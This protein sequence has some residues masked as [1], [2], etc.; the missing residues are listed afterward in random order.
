MRFAF[1]ICLLNSRPGVKCCHRRVWL[2]AFLWLAFVS[3]LPALENEMVCRESQTFLAPGDS[4]EARKYAPSREIDILHLA[5]DVTPDFKD[6]SVSGKVTLRF[7]AVAKPLQE[8][9]LDGVDL[10]VFSVVSTEKIMGWQAT[11]KNVIVTFDQPIAP[12]KEASVTITY[13][14]QPQRSKG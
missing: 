10:T 11:D 12:D 14:A 4:S 3:H 8:L 13:R 5:L 1:E 9:R 2:A 7:K 6:R